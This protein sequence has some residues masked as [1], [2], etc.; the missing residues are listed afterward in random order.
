MREP[1]P[2]PGAIEQI[3]SELGVTDGEMLN[4]GRTLDRA[5]AEL[6]A[7]AAERTA[8]QRW[9]SAVTRPGAVTNTTVVTR[10]VV[11]GGHPARGDKLKTSMRALAGRIPQAQ[12]EPLQAEPLTPDDGQ[13]RDGRC[14]RVSGSG[15]RAGVPIPTDGCKP[16]REDLTLRELV[17]GEQRG[18]ACSWTFR[19][20]E[21]LVVSCAGPPLATCSYARPSHCPASHWA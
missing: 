16:W 1:D 20:V 2:P 3:L 12:P 8:P 7:D 14:Q 6:I 10:Q 4:Q 19:K 15:R 13:D 21:P 11:A 5:A 18:R 9:H 17:R